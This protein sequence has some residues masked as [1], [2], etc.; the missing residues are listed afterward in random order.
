MPAPVLQQRAQ[1]VQRIEGA[2]QGCF[3]RKYRVKLFGSTCYGADSAASDLDLVI[4]VS[5][6]HPPAK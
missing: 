3:G 6:M 5:A 1:A 4:V 2:I